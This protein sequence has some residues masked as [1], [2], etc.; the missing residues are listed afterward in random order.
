[1]THPVPTLQGTVNTWNCDEVGHMNVQFYFAAGADAARIYAASKKVSGAVY[2]QTD[3]VRFHRELRAGDIFNVTTLPVGTHDSG[4]ILAHQVINR[5]TGELSA[6]IVSNTSLPAGMAEDRFGDIPEAARPRSIAAR[7]S[8]PALTLNDPAA[9][10]LIPIYQGV[11]HADQCNEAGA[12]RQQFIMSRFSD[13]AAHLW[14][15]VGFDRDA[16]LKARRGTVV[17]ETR[18]DRLTD[19]RAG[20]VLIARSAIVEIMGKVLRFAHFLFDGSTG[21][22]V[23]TGEAAAVLLDLDARKTVAFGEAERAGL[24]PYLME[25]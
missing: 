18:L 22:L 5:G 10:K 23:A 9:E 6:T 21:S 20:T 12:M 15:H 2:S 14:H 24:A 25:F 1:M 4:L 3:H 19:V 17:L 11:V 8:L 13:G 16:M 7:S